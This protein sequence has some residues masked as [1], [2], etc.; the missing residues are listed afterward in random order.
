MKSFFQLKFL[1]PN[2][3]LALFILRVWLGLSMIVIHGLP[4]LQKL[5]N[6][7]FNFGDKI[8]IGSKNTL[9]L[10]VVVEIV[11]SLFLALGFC[12]RF[13]A[14]LL[15]ITMGVAF[16]QWHEMKLVG[17]GNGELAFIYLAGFVT[18]VL[19]GPGKYGID[20]S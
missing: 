20:R 7:D 11:G 18:I 6:G 13:A 16:V 5:L 8:G 9:I 12:G 19:A 14:L 17:P 15:A 4:K 2:P 10:A 1:P 3:G